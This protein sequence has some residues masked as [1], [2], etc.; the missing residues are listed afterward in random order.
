MHI[1]D[2]FLS[3]PVWGTL[4]AVAIPTV[5][6]ISRSAQ[7]SFDQHRAPLLGVLGAFVFAAQ[8][9]NFPVGI[10]TSG[11]LVGG[12]LLMFTL[13]PGAA[14][15]VMTAILILQSLVFQDGGVLALGANVC[16]MA[17]AGVFAAYLVQRTFGPRR[18]TYFVGGAVS[19][20]V[21]AM[22]ALSE[23]LLSGVRMPRSVLWASVAL[24]VVS[25]LVE[26]A[27]TLV[28]MESLEKIN[29][30]FVRDGG[31]RSSSLIPAVALTSFVL[32]TVGFL[33]ASSQPDGIWSLAARV[34]LATHAQ[35][36]LSTPLADYKAGFINQPWLSR[37]FAGI[38]GLCLVYI[39]C[40]AISRFALRRNAGT[41]RSA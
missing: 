29:P 18:L 26:G 5:A 31:R 27:I 19:L 33:I 23:L 41:P 28:V 11:H 16:N 14:S 4:D 10:G 22:L 3:T 40:W 39:V 13:G 2:G 36:T 9:I 37:A 24:F 25:A 30:G 8:M 17:I 38:G 35:A 6:W 32:V 12:A 20:L 21:S 1:P 7:N 15:I 34:G